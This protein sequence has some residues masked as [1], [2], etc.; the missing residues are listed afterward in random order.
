MAHA[1]KLFFGTDILF[2]YGPLGYLAFPTFP[3]AGIWGPLAFA[4]VIAGITA[5]A[6]TQIIRFSVLSA[7]W[8]SMTTFWLCS[9]I[10]FA[11]PIAPLERLIFAATAL[12]LS[13]GLRIK[14]KPWFDVCLL[15]FLGA[16]ALL[17]KVSLVAPLAIGIYFTAL[18]TW[19]SSSNG[20][21]RWTH[22]ALFSAVFLTSFFGL[23]WWSNGTLRSVGLFLRGSME[24]SN[25]YSDAMALAGPLWIVVLAIM[26]C[27][28]LFT[29]VP[30][31]SGEARSMAFGFFPVAIL[32][33]ESFK[34]AMV[35]EDGHCV[36][37]QVELALF[38]LVLIAFT[39][40]RRSRLLIF[41]FSAVS[42]M[43]GLQVQNVMWPQ[44]AA[45]EWD[46]ASG[47]A[48]VRDL[49]GFLNWPAT[50]RTLA[51]ASEQALAPAR[52]PPEFA[53]AP[54]LTGQS[55]TAVPFQID[56]VRANHL[57]WQP[58]PVMQTY[59]AYTAALDRLNANR[60]RVAGAPSNILLFW[61]PIDGHQPFYES[62]QTWRELFNFYDLQLKV[63]GIYVLK[64]R[65]APRFKPPIFIGATV[66][67]WGENVFVP[68]VNDDQML[69]MQSDIRHNLKGVMSTALLR[70]PAVYI[71]A[72][73]RTGKKTTSPLVRMSLSEG[74]IVSD[75]PM[76]L[77]DVVPAFL[78]KSMGPQQ[79]VT[80][81][82]FR[83]DAPD[84][85]QSSIRIRWLRLQVANN[86]EPLPSA[87]PI[88]LT[89][90]WG[91]DDAMPTISNAQLRRNPDYIE[92]K[93]LNTDPQC[94]FNITGDLAQ[95]KTIMIRAK[96]QVSDRIDLFFG[97]Q[98]NGRGIAGFV[99]SPESWIDAYFNVEANPYWAAE[100]GSALRFDPTSEL[101]VNSVVQIAGI[102][103]SRD[104]LP[105][106]DQVLFALPRANK[107][108]F[109][110]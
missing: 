25:G 94:L 38:A 27:V 107:E 5:Y 64:H 48:I 62:P 44:L 87:P 15:F 100:H 66:V 28:V 70:A 32:A 2:T 4:W 52:I 77:N 63:P 47:G 34:S 13:I 71:D 35:R 74:A 109:Q 98:I 18:L 85:F 12:S 26:S 23:F 80:S 39:Q 30:L 61:N 45:G 22:A 14:S 50:V 17:C 1:N 31:A 95:Y 106:P 29:V 102:W 84:R 59:A 8:L 11:N 67:R 83:T 68:Q 103:G 89:R 51:F 88:Q 6:L 60:M 19:Q 20:L 55:V 41:S 65:S 46:R 110:N 91:V 54:L 75:W 3:E 9:I 69:I 33:F 73:L 79:R 57:K 105:S 104:P 40:A 24:L 92:I 58:L 10:L 49:R 99:R 93:S 7:A 86:P 82:T 53:F 42:V 78:G 21:A 76:G 96:Y 37:F 36:Q 81:I 72:T 90:L 101:G 43:L 97:P 108:I 16:V 56:F